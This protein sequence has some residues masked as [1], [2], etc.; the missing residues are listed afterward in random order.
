MAAV[1]TVDAMDETGTLPFLK[2]ALEQNV[3]AWS[4]ACW[5]FLQWERE[6]ILFQEP[7]SVQREQHRSTLRELLL[8]TRLLLTLVSTA[9][10]HN[11]GLRRE[12]QGRLIQLE[13]SSAVASNPMTP[14]DAR[15]ILT[16]AFPAEEKFI[17]QLFA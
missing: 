13:E 1:N 11:S 7:T 2:N 14:H 15:T 12:L 5:K 10:F 8:G 16:E 9:D 17:E 3:R 4:D 6:H